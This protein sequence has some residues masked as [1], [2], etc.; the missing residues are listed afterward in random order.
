[1]TAW[2]LFTISIGVCLIA[3]MYI[4]YWL[5]WCWTWHFTW[6][7]GPQWLVRPNVSSFLLVN[8][9]GLI[10]TLVICSRASE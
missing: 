3:C 9:T 2:E 8:I 5:C 7:T 10:I 1:M 6:P 4:G